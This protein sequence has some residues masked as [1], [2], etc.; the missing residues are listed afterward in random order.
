MDTIH[1]HV[2]RISASDV[3]SILSTLFGAQASARVVEG[4]AGAAEKGGRECGGA[5]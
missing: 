3:D 4:N 2:P 5:G 1:T